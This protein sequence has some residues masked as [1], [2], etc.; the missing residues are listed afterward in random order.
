MKSKFILLSVIS[1]FSCGTLLTDSVVFASNQENDNFNIENSNAG[2][3]Q[4]LTAAEVMDRIRKGIPNLARQKMRGNDINGHIESIVNA[5]K[6][7]DNA[8][9]KNHG[10]KILL[11]AVGYDFDMIVDCLIQRNVDPRINIATGKRE[12]MVRFTVPLLEFAAK[13]QSINS[14]KIL[15]KVPANYQEH[16]GIAPLSYAVIH[17]HPGVVDEIL[18]LMK[19]CASSGINDQDSGIDEQDSVGGT[20]LYN[21]VAYE[22]PEFVKKLLDAGADPNIA[23]DTDLTPL[24]YAALYGSPEIVESLLK[25]GADP[26]LANESGMTPFTAVAQRTFGDEENGYGDQEDVDVYQEDVNDAIK[27]M[28]SL[29]E[30]DADPH[31]ADGDN[32]TPLALI[33]KAGHVELLQY[34]LNGEFV[35]AAE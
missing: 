4:T 28:K 18:R 31:K 16:N 20:A 11:Q 2:K 1:A 27:I 13:R 9:I 3:K 14:M 33:A 7:V 21:A 32:M 19:E 30:F 17:N 24:C 15:L 26:N 10:Q 6:K 8:T 12:D 25:A 5:L 23:E 29:L 34:M 35:D 22:R